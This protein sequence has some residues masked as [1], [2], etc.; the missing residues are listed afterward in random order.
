VVDQ[1][2]RHSND[3]NYFITNLSKYLDCKSSQ[4]SLGDVVWLASDDKGEY[5]LDYVIERKAIDDLAGSIMDGRYKE[6]R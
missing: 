4:L 2:E 3:R 6:Q 5:L 1:R